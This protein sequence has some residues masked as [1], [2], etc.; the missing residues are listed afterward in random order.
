MK[1]L[2]LITITILS[3]FSCRQGKYSGLILVDPNTGSKYML[4]TYD[5]E[6]YIVSKQEMRMDGKDT[7]YVFR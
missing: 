4:N 6:T 3:L 7:T 1:K 2:I 5:G